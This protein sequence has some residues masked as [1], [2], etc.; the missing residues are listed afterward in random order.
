MLWLLCPTIPVHCI[1]FQCLLNAR[2]ANTSGR[3]PECHVFLSASAF[4]AV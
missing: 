2:A 4:A 1:T 3:L